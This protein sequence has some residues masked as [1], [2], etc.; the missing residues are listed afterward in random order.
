M[1]AAVPPMIDARPGP[2]CPVDGSAPTFRNEL[3]QVPARNCTSYTAADHGRAA[4]MCGPLHL[5]VLVTGPA[6]GELA[7]QA[8]DGLPKVYWPR[9]HAVPDSEALYLTGYAAD[10]GTI[11]TFE[12]HP[13][14]DVWT[15]AQRYDVAGVVLGP[16]ARLF[17]ESQ[18]SGPSRGPDRR[19]LFRALDPQNAYTETLYELRFADEMWTVLRQQT[20]VSLRVPQIREPS[21]GADGLELVFWSEHNER[22]PIT[23]IDNRVRRQWYASRRSLNDPFGVAVELATVPSDVTMPFL[24]DD[25]ERIYFSALNSVF[26]LPY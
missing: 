4:A 17:S 1:D 2:Q 26:Y 11:H 15:V 22:D 9:V 8:I 19:L 14:D 12:L 24:A 18:Q 20:V 7:V 10:V 5:E 6:D 3:I 23:N 16:G 25:C 21:I 13:G